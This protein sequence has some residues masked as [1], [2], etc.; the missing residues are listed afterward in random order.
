MQKVYLYLVCYAR[1]WP[2]VYLAGVF[3][4]HRRTVSWTPSWPYIDSQLHALQRSDLEQDISS[5]PH[6]RGN[7][8]GEFDHNH[9]EES[10]QDH[11]SQTR[12]IIPRPARSS[13]RGPSVVRRPQKITD[14]I[15]WRASPHH[16]TTPSNHQTIIIYHQ[17]TK[18]LHLSP[19]TY[20]TKR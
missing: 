11:D 1:V 4:H 12:R 15:S 9:C 16:N 5:S 19:Y 6:Y 7:H 8:L 3:A 14:N 20:A 17:P 2:I 18:R 13:R 10:P